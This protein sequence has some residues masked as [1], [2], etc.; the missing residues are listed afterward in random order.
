MINPSQ[1]IELKRL[2]KDEM[3]RR[4]GNG[5]LAEF[6]SAHYDFSVAP[7]YGQKTKPEHGQKTIDLLLKIKD[8][9]DLRLVREDEAIPISFDASL[10][11]YVRMLSAEQ[12]TGELSDRSSCRGACTG[13]CVGSCIGHCNGC[14]GCVATCGTG[15]DGSVMV[16]SR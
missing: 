16:S 6:A 15:C 1:T 14:S 2:I 12:A 8:Y 7:A 3:A 4:N 10:L 9:G 13:L 5:S 11:D